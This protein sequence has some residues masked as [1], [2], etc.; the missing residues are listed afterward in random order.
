M[1][2]STQVIISLYGIILVML[3]SFIL[4]TKHLGYKGTV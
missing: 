2:Y 4:G 3:T 1:R